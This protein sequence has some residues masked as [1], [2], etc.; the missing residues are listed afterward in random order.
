MIGNTPNSYQD[1]DVLKLY[2]ELRVDLTKTHE[3]LAEMVAYSVAHNF[4]LGMRLWKDIL[5]YIESNPE[6]YLAE[7]IA[8]VRAEYSWMHEDGLRTRILELLKRKYYYAFRV[9]YKIHNNLT[10]NYMNEDRVCDLIIRSPEMQ[11]IL[12]HGLAEQSQHMSSDIQ[13]AGYWSV[14]Q[15]VALM[16]QK[17]EYATINDILSHIFVEDLANSHQHILYNCL[18][19]KSSNIDIISLG[20]KRFRDEEVNFLISMIEA[21]GAT[22]E[23]IAS[24]STDIYTRAVITDDRVLSNTPYVVRKYSILGDFIEERKISSFFIHYRVNRTTLVAIQGY[25]WKLHSQDETISSLDVKRNP[26]CAIIHD[27]RNNPIPVHNIR[28]DSIPEDHNIV[29]F[30]SDGITVKASY[31]TIADACRGANASKFDIRTSYQKETWCGGFYWSVLDVNKLPK[32]EFSFITAQRKN[33]VVRQYT[34]Q[35]NFLKE[36]DKPELAAEKNNLSVKDLNVAL[37]TARLDKSE[38]NGF[39]WR[40]C[41]K[42]SARTDITPFVAPVEM[43]IRRYSMDGQYMDNYASTAEASVATGITQDNI[44]N[45][46]AGRNDSAGGFLWRKC[47]VD[48]PAINIEVKQATSLAGKRIL[49]L[50]ISGEILNEFES[51]SAASQALNINQKSI[52]D[53]IKGRQRTA[54]GYCWQVKLD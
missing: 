49:Q 8:D 38:L 50:A 26:I 12:Y 25:L 40:K 41:D 43:E 31:A 46:I 14:L 17:G 27:A 52:R 2:M 20:V 22:P 54:G 37:N 21:Y 45:A 4:E 15:S 42:S 9:N 6:E 39:M 10:R 51:V 33:Y 19:Y 36:Y 28:F 48:S 34:L 30:G 1:I 23:I 29:Q 3:R 13:N 5:Q 7:S 32:D 24:I 16:V 11:V 18:I 44:S 53:T 47:P 35:G